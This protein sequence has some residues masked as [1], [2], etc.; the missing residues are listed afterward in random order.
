MNPSGSPELSAS[1][2]SPGM[3]G[4]GAA[5]I[6]EAA[7]RTSTLYRKKPTRKSATVIGENVASLPSARL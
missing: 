7:E 1:R 6:P 3:V 5:A 2:F 4:S